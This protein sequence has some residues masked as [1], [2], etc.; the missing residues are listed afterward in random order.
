MQYHVEYQ[1]VTKSYQAGENKR[2]VIDHTT[3][4]IEKGEYVW[5]TGK[6]GSGKSSFLNMLTGIDKPDSGAVCVNGEEI[7][8]MEEKEL[9]KWRGK[10]IGIVFQFF[11]LIPT[12]SAIEN[13]LLPM[14]LVGKIPAKERQKRAEKLLGLVGLKND[15]EKLPSQMSGGEQQRVAIARALANDADL[16][17]AD[18]PT[19]NL[20]SQNTDMIF[21]IFE[22]LNH[23]GKT[24]IMVTHESSLRPEI[25]RNIVVKDGKIVKDTTFTQE[26]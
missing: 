24:I 20:D 25:T 19:G 15:G 2:T 22:E 12:L 17:V 23:L 18:E 11:Q 26:K 9:A 14:D 10:N 7:T 1:N 4:G 21:S 6:S 16:L 5:I 13:V 3:V 8:S